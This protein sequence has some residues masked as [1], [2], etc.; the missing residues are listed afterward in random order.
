VVTAVTNTGVTP[1]ATPVT[2]TTIMAR[3]EAT[4]TGTLT[5]GPD[6]PTAAT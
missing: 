6:G 4:A 3:V 5:S 2:R 1:P